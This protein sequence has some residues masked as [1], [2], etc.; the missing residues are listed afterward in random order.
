VHASRALTEEEFAA[1]ESL[2]FA[3]FD[4]RFAS[5]SVQESAILVAWFFRNL[6][7]YIADMKDKP[8]FTDAAN[9]REAGL[10]IVRKL[11]FPG[12]QN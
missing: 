1:A 10:K 5:L 6:R 2:E 11:P 12:S 4:Q 7:P 8:L 9:L 3:R